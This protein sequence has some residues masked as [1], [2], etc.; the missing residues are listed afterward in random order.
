MRDVIATPGFRHI[1]PRDRLRRHACNK[2]MDRYDWRPTE[3]EYE[4][5]CELADS[6]SG[7]LS[8]DTVP[9]TSRETQ[10]WPEFRGGKA[11]VVFDRS[12]RAIVTILKGWRNERLAPLIVPRGSRRQNRARY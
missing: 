6:F 7:R 4:A 11:R 2:I 5:L 9:N 3:A 1:P 8:D 12:E 10:L